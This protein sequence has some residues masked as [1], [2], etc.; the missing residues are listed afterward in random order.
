MKKAKIM[1]VL[2]IQYKKIHIL[3]LIETSLIRSNKAKM[4]V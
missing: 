3:A 4:K 2:I 1:K